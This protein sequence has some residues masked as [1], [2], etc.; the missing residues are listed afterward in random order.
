VDNFI[1]NRYLAFV[2][3]TAAQLFLIY[4]LWH[5]TDRSRR[6]M[7]LAYLLAALTQSATAIWLSASRTDR[8]Q[9][10]TAAHEAAAYFTFSMKALE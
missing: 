7:L 6:T 4:R 3:A 1:D 5:I 2:V 8:S 9:Q 10:F